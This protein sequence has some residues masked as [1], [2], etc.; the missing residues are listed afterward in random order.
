V[1]LLLANFPDQ[2]SD[3]GSTLI[4]ASCC[5]LA[6]L[7][8]VQAMFKDSGDSVFAISRVKDPQ[9]LKGRGGLFSTQRGIAFFKR[10]PS[11][12]HLSE[13]RGREARIES[14][15]Q[16]YHRSKELWINRTALT[17]PPASPLLEIWCTWCC[18]VLTKL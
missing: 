6:A 15:E 13:E 7:R 4:I 9:F 5:N 3:T 8:R 16:H 18:M 1:Y 10:L 12:N 2:A 14:E 11:R 17:A